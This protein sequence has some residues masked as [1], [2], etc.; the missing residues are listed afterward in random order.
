MGYED[1]DWIH[2]AKDR[3]QWQAIV[4]HRVPQKAGI[5]SLAKRLFKKDSAPW[6]WLPK[7]LEPVNYH[8]CKRIVVV[9]LLF[10]RSSVIDF[11]AQLGLL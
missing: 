8:S 10:E 11:L 9:S 6:N 7:N 3:D 1:V 5:S 2:L 4:N